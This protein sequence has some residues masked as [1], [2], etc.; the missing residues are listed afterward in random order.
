MKNV[1]RNQFHPRSCVYSRIFLFL[2]PYTFAGDRI[3]SIRYWKNWFSSIWSPSRVGLVFCGRQSPGGHNVVWGLYNA[4]KTHNPNS[5]LLGFLGKSILLL[6]FWHGVFFLSSL[7]SF[8]LDFWTF[9]CMHK[10][11]KTWPISFKILN[12][13]TFC[14]FI[15]IYICFCKPQIHLMA[16]V[17]GGHFPS[18]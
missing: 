17:Q 13:V 3:L 11:P 7:V 9:P 18:R 15:R 2:V 8:K 5:T 16:P 12:N 4:L 1:L 10:Y 6:L 14:H